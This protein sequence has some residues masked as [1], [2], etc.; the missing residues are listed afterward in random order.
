MGRIGCARITAA[1]PITPAIGST[2]P[3]N[4][5]YQKLFKRDINTV[6]APRAVIAQVKD[7]ARRACITG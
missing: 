2:I 7:V 6:A 3:D 1:A 4:C 5:P